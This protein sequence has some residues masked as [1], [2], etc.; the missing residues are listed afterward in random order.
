MEKRSAAA[1]V[2]V[3]WLSAV[4]SAATLSYVVNR[5]AVIVEGTTTGAVSRTAGSHLRPNVDEVNE[6][7]VLELPT[8]VIVGEVPVPR[9]GVA[10][11]QRVDDVIVGPGVVTHP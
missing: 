6:S 2:G 4:A 1:V 5:P 3:V 9:T 8:V 10:E 11:M 7:P